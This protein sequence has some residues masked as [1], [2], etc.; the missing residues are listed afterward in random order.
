MFRNIPCSPCI[1]VHDLKRVRCIFDRPLC[2]H[3]IPEEA[4]LR[5]ATEMLATARG[6]Q[7][8]AVGAAR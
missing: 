8:A 5:A 3:E 6:L 2:L 7:S 4:A 1:N